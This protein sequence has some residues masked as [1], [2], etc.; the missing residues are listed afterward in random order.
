M[1]ISL[2]QTKGG[3]G[4]STL[5]LLLAYS[6]TIRKRF[7][8]VS[9]LDLDY[10]G[11]LNSWVRERRKRVGE[12]IGIKFDSYTGEK[13]KDFAKVVKSLYSQKKDELLIIDSGGEGVLNFGTSKSISLPDK[14]IIPFHLSQTNE[15]AFNRNL[16][17]NIEADKTKNKYFLLPSF[18]HTSANVS[19]IC[20][21]IKTRIVKDNKNMKVMRSPFYYRS[22]FQNFC[23]YGLSLPEYK[24]LYKTNKKETERATKADKD[25]I[26]ISKEIIRS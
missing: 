23:R 26:T 8:K 14:V 3:V 6:P 17:P 9:V 12:D 4:K 11:T 22:I 13:D 20:E 19:N 5:A 7:P 25:V 18:I 16:K 1:I 2:L 24:S 10:Q 21:E 15:D